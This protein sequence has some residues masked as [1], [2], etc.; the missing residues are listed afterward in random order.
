MFFP[1]VGLSRS[2]LG[3]LEPRHRLGCFKEMP[4]LDINKI[5]MKL[6]FIVC[7][8]NAPVYLSDRFDLV[9]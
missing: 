7:V 5:T 4:R 3:R 8:H 2:L 9:Y 1:S 6:V